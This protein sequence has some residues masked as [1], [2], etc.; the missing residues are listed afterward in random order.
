MPFRR[1]K[2]VTNFMTINAGRATPLSEPCFDAQLP[3]GSLDVILCLF[4]RNISVD[5]GLSLEKIKS[6]VPNPILLDGCPRRR[7]VI[8]T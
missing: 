7:V 3:F 4:F 8:V 6:D 1:A 2:L 5:S